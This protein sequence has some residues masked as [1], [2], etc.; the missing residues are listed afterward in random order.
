MSIIFVKL[1]A[2]NSVRDGNGTRLRVVK[3]TADPRTI[4]AR[5]GCRFPA[6]YPGKTMARVA[7]VVYS[8]CEELFHSWWRRLRSSS[9][10]SS[11]SNHHRRSSSQQSQRKKKVF[12]TSRNEERRVVFHH[13]ATTM[14][15]TKIETTVLFPCWTLHNWR[16][17]WVESYVYVGWFDCKAANQKCRENC[18]LQKNGDRG[19]R[20]AYVPSRPVVVIAVAY[21]GLKKVQNGM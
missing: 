18:I 1:N 20:L 14:N 13:P 7:V 15:I 6:K 8:S 21:S 19:N 16:K 5:V 12:F 9:S 11:R 17:K 10:S 2:F 4:S 3:V